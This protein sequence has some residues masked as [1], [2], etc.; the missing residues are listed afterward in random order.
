MTKLQYLIKVLDKPRIRP[1]YPSMLPYRDVPATHRRVS[2]RLGKE[3][4]P[5]HCPRRTTDRNKPTRNRNRY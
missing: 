1:M 5:L 3:E 2:A 4:K